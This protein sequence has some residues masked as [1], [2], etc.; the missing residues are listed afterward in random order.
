MRVIYIGPSA[1]GV[2]VALPDGG[3]IECAHGGDVDVA[4]E[5]GRRLLEQPANWKRAGV[6]AGKTEGEGDS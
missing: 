5:H 6:K 2:V 1:T 3:E 4:D